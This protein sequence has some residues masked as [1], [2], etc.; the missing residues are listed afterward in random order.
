M[1][2]VD[3]HQDSHN[4]TDRRNSCSEVMVTTTGTVAVTVIVAL[5]APVRWPAL[6]YRRCASRLYCTPAAQAV[7]AS[8]PQAKTATI[9][10]TVTATVAVKLAMTCA[11]GPGGGVT[12]RD[13]GRKLPPPPLG[14]SGQQ[15][16]PKGAALWSPWAPKA[17]NAPWAPKPPKGKFCPLCTPALSLN[18]TLTL[19][20]TQAL[21]LVLTRIEYW[22]RAGGGRNIV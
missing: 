11:C 22:D 1:P 15:L 13:L 17:P 14:A 16:V 19:T 3:A 6:L 5:R 12:P 4:D 21:N 20:P 18:P 7:K 10:V 2:R 8:S 9:T